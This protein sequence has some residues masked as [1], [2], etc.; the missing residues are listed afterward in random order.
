MHDDTQIFS[1]APES[2]EALRRVYGEEA[3]FSRI[4][5]FTLVHLDSPTPEQLRKREVEFNPDDFF[6]DDCPLCVSAKEAGGHIVCAPR[7][8]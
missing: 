3:L 5:R 2:D 7:G 8:A 4:G 1:T 6:F